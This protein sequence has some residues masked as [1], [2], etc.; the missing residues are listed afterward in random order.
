MQ[1]VASPLGADT[2]FSLHIMLTLTFVHTNTRGLRYGDEAFAMAHAKLLEL[3]PS[4]RTQPAG[5]KKNAGLTNTTQFGVAGVSDAFGWAGDEDAVV[6][7]SSAN[8]DRRRFVPLGEAAGRGGG[9]FADQQMFSCGSLAPK[10]K[11]KGGCMD[12]GFM[13]PQEPWE[14]TDGAL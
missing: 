5:S 10:L 13:R 9:G 11:R 2:F 4:A 14:L 6:G 8:S 7:G 12:C 1:H 3:L